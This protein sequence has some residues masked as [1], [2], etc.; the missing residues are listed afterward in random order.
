M[1]EAR[2]AT[3]GL[4]VRVT[5]AEFDA[6]E[7]VAKKAGVEKR[8]LVLGALAE[9]YPE[10]ADVLSLSPGRST[11]IE[12]AMLVLQGESQAEAARATHLSESMVTLIMQRKRHPEARGIAQSRLDSG[13]I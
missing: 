3:R 4:S 2:K 1:S 11:A 7:A 6:I 13:I 9:L 8:A 12:A 5:Q 10:I